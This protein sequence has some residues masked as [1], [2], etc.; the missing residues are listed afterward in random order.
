M[1][2]LGDP[3]PTVEQSLPILEKGDLVT[4]S[5]KG[6]PVT[7]LVDHELRVKRIVVEARERGVLIDVGHGSGS[8]SW[9]VARA[10]TEQGYWPDTISTDVH[11]GSLPPPIAAD[12]P[13]VMSKFLHL[14]M[15]LE[16]VIRAST[17]RPALAIGW[18]DRIGSL[19]V[20]KAADV[21]VLALEAG[22]FALTD[23]Y[24]TPETARQRLVARH[25]I[26]GG[27]VLE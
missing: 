26:C 16:A 7:R 20:G 1:L 10:M 23:S 12:M 27:Q 19:E 14:G 24:K 3:P 22:E 25:T 15:P 5:Y 21:A 11:K 13:N 9:P 17:I 2:H 8:F 6:Q 4:H 18:A